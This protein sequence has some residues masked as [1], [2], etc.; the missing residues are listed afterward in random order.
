[1]KNLTDMQTQFPS[2]LT[3]DVKSG[4]ALAHTL[5]SQL[6]AQIEAARHDVERPGGMNYL[7]PAPTPKEITAGILFYAIAA[8][9]QGWAVKD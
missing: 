2:L 4:L 9:N 5:A 8:A 6:H 3:A 1:M 7:L